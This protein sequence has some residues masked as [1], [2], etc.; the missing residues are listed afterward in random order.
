MSLKQWLI[1]ANIPGISFGMNEKTNGFTYQGSPATLI[2][3]VQRALSRENDGVQRLQK[4]VEDALESD[5]LACLASKVSK[6]LTFLDILMRTQ[7]M[8]TAIMECL[9]DRLVEQGS[10]DDPVSADSNSC[11]AFSQ[12]PSISS[13]AI[14]K[15]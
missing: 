9:L 5:E 11:F 10:V 13:L 7:E 3:A 2:A 6:D 15:H 1:I 8:Q 12:Q 14:S 4:S